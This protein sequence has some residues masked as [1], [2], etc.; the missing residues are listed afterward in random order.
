MKKPFNT[1]AASAEAQFPEFNEATLSTMTRRIA[2]DLKAPKNSSQPRPS[3]DQTPKPSKSAK[4]KDEARRG[5]KRDRAGQVKQVQ[6]GRGK[7]LSKPAS[8]PPKG[9]I[10][11]KTDLLQEILALGGTKDDL[12]LVGDVSSGSESLDE[13]GAK[14]GES[15]P[16]RVIKGLHN[17]VVNLVQEL[18]LGEA[19]LQH[20][21]SD[22]E[23]TSSQDNRNGVD[24]GIAT[25]SQKSR[26]PEPSA[27]EPSV[28]KLSSSKGSSPAKS[29]VRLIV[30]P[31]PDWHAADLPALPLPNKG[32]TAPSSDVIDRLYQRAISLLESDNNGYTSSQLSSTSSHRF[33][34]TIMSSG[35][36]SDKVSAL[37]LVVQESPLHNVKAFESLIGLARK[38]SRGQA[39]TAL[40]ALKDLL[41]Q[42]AVLPP[43][44]RLRAFGSQPGLVGA[45]QHSGKS[46][47]TGDGLPDGLQEIHLVSWAYEDWLKKTY[48]EMLK[49]LE[50]WCNDE[51]DFARG[52]A[53][54]YVWELLKEKPE[55]ESNLLRLLVNKV[56]D[57]DK[58]IAS[59]ASFLLLQLQATHPLM[60]PVIISS[61]ESELLFRPG[62]S[63]HAKYYA[64]ITLNQTILSLK[65]EQLAGK[66]LE[67]YFS[68]FVA[69]LK[70]SHAE[71]KTKH[72]QTEPRKG[73]KQARDGAHG[74]TF[75]KHS[76]PKKPIGSSDQE[77]H[78]KMI[79]AVLTGVNRAISFSKTDDN[80]F[81]NHMD[82]LF[83]ITHSSNFNTSVQA[84]KLI[85]QIS[86]SDQLSADRFYRTLYESLLD[87]RLIAS[88]KQAMYLNMLFQSLRSDLNVKRVK[89]FVKRLLQVITLHQPPFICGVLY[90][91]KELESTFPSIKA[92]L[93]QPQ[94]LDDAD[95]EVF[96]DA[97][98]EGDTSRVNSI[99][100]VI[101]ADQTKENSRDHRGS[102]DCYDG[103]K[104]DPEHSNAH[105]SCLWE[106]TPFLSHFHPSVS[107]FASR[108]LLGGPMPAKPDLSLH[109]LIHFLDRFVYRN[110]K[111]DSAGLRGTSIMQP[112]AGG[113]TSEFLI[114]AKGNNRSQIP[115]NMESFW[116]KKSED[117]A[118]DEVF[119]HRYFNQMS[120]G[121]AAPQKRTSSPQSGE[122]EDDDEIWEALVESRPELEGDEDSDGDLELG[123]LDSEG[124]DSGSEAGSEEG[125]EPKSGVEHDESYSAGDNAT[126]EE[127]DTLFDSEDEVPSDLDDVFEEE[128]E[129]STKTPGA[130]VGRETERKKRRKLKH[131]PTFASAEDYAE[132]LAGDDEESF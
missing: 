23:S 54:G 80:T 55:Q 75:D 129:T 111:S 95:E 119:F 103:R 39:V 63:D 106:L 57:P 120:K 47:K 3:K 132:M 50:I 25:A 67:I 2:D 107:L 116:G 42:G 125:P 101:T 32:Q 53:I 6:Q 117:V 94:E 20:D 15:N 127:E 37:T 4:S 102:H 60:K 58:K 1:P 84:L 83:R 123:D 104:R 131:L 78:E 130:S 115:V 128:L 33:L 40:G 21:P 68:L 66:L 73:Q 124:S 51:V 34:S 118:V 69:L 8:V 24:G 74:K 27:K 48:F 65:E 122:E 108:L 56:G 49:I 126:L 105:K 31:R 45:L 72:R 91:I 38:R 71:E 59:K 17:D 121:K 41:A 30:K 93:D 9:R 43:Q 85:Q 13:K 36:L 99:G 26:V 89:A 98:D 109:T 90:L 46:W 87:P 35:T 5:L 97:P 96:V 18:G 52:R 14:A 16:R 114:S 70:P 22:L 61:I 92:L 29:D 77:L 19:S 110:A 81:R 64:I 44:R 82:T 88:S 7:I 112:M 28:A 86:K 62:Q 10:A 100:R 79:S 12:E 113:D 76:D 11:K